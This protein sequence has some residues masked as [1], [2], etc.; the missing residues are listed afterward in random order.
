MLLQKLVQIA[1]RS[2]ISTQNSTRCN[3]TPGPRRL[4]M[5]PAQKREALRI[6]RENSRLAK[7]IMDPNTS[8]KLQK[9]NEDYRKTLKYKQL[10][11][12]PRLLTA[13]DLPDARSP[14]PPLTA[15]A[16][17]SD[18]VTPLEPKLSLDISV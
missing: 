12:K 3:N 9:W 16:R 15:E 6:E 1:G 8:F 14:L 10:L 11:A 2:V 13:L 7:K 4:S 5:S 18:R 17:P